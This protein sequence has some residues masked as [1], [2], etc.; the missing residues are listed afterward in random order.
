MAVMI[1]FIAKY[2]NSIKTILNDCW[3]LIA[4]I[5]GWGKRVSIQGDIQLIANK[6]ISDLNN[7]VPELQMPDLEIEWV[8]ADEDGQ[9]RFDKNK[10]IVMLKF[11]EDRTQN[12]INS[13]S[14]YIH[15]TLLTTSRVY[16]D[17]P[18]VKAIDY[19]IIHKFI[20]LNNK[21]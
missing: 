11:N 17:E 8:K 14:A 5:T 20:L 10:A 13:T 3:Y 19:T 21:L 1:A 12:V 18:I 7:I 9:V 6:S 15:N 4:K 16:M 2:Y